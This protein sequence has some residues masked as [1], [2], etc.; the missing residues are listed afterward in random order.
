MHPASSAIRKQP[1]LS[2]TV[3]PC[4]TILDAKLAGIAPSVMLRPASTRAAASAVS[5]SASCQPP[6]ER[7]LVGKACKARN[8][9]KVCACRLGGGAG[10]GIRG[11][12]RRRW[13]VFNR[14]ATPLE[15]SKPI[16]GVHAILTNYPVGPREGVGAKEG[17]G[18]RPYAAFEHRSRGIAPRAKNA[19]DNQETVSRYRTGQRDCQVRDASQGERQEITYPQVGLS[20]PIGTVLED[21]PT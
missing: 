14:S 16:F 13:T 4:M 3:C 20:R 15:S 7:W 17:A 21:H 18:G 2:M 11:R 9:R 1:R 8:A 10:D 12:P 19:R 6:G 5:P